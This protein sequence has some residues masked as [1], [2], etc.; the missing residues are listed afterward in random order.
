MAATVTTI[1]TNTMAIP[2]TKVMIATVDVS[3]LVDRR[4]QTRPVITRQNDDDDDGC[5]DPLNTRQKT[6]Y[7]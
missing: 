1:K 6:T 4:R 7:E 5:G 3:F 2:V